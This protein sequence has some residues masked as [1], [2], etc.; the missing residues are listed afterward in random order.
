MIRKLIRENKLYSWMVV[1]IILI[2]AGL[3]FTHTTKPLLE[4]DPVLA[5]QEFKDQVAQRQSIL[6]SVMQ[7]RQEVAFSFGLISFFLLA[8]LVSGC[9]FSFNYI[10]KRRNGIEMIPRTLDAPDP[11]WGI[12]DVLRIVILFVFFNHLFSLLSVIL[13]NTFLSS[14][15]DRRA[16]IV[17]ATGLMDLLLLMFILRFVVVRYNQNVSTLGIS[18][19]GLLKNAGIGLYSYIGFLPILA[20]I[21]LSMV[22]IARVLNY[23][24]PPQPIYE[25][26]FEEKR[27]SVIIIMS[28][29][30]TVIG[31]VI[32]EVF[33]RG[34]LYG[35]LKK[36]FGIL[37]AI[38]L[39]ALFF[40]FLHTNILAFIPIMALG[41]F[42]AYIREKTGSLMPAIFVHILHNTL[43][44][45]FMFFIRELTSKV[46]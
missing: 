13:K 46:S 21:F 17:A 28:C 35:A 3:I 1:F 18:T 12:G 10:S 44:S 11:L 2:Q 40:S 39:S 30:I 45:S 7:E 6:R 24:P 42:L 16:G 14:G 34:F 22:A 32:E 4:K 9:V 36:S 31:P 38:I 19:N 29:L 43:L 41:I 25:L 8:G 5:L 26:I 20:A 23:T 27:T 37:W 33:F 15:L